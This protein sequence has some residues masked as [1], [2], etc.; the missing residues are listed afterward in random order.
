M[1]ERCDNFLYVWWEAFPYSAS[2][3]PGLGSLSYVIDSQDLLNGKGRTVLCRERGMAIN[4]TPLIVAN[5][6]GTR[7]N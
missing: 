7:F 1:H 3:L 4:T 5:V 6:H 2:C